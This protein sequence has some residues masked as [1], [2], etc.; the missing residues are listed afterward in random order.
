MSRNLRKCE[1]CKE[2]YDT[3]LQLLERNAQHHLPVSC[4]AC[5][6]TICHFCFVDWLT[7]NQHG[8]VKCPDCDT[9]DGFNADEPNHVNHFACLLLAST[10][11][12]DTMQPAATKARPVVTATSVKVARAPTTPSKPQQKPATV[13]PDTVKTKKRKQDETIEYDHLL[14]SDDDDDDE[15]DV[16]DDE[17]DDDDE[18]EPEPVPEKPRPTKK[19][20]RSSKLNISVEEMEA[21][22]QHIILGDD[23]HSGMERYLREEERMAN[24]EPLSEQNVRNVMRQVKKFCSGEGV[25]YKHWPKG[26]K[27][28]EGEELHLGMD[29]ELMLKAAKDFEDEYGR[30]KGNGWLLRHPITKLGNY[31][32]WVLENE[33]REAHLDDSD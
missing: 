4:K 16:D 18:L 20:K 12:D 17:D 27:F 28:L 30:D 25:E 1:R 8:F 21:L 15:D 2:V 19:K 10:A 6:Y 32:R 26:T 31:Q 24:G 13:T 7:K 11:D 22:E 9:V 29:F 14:S 3:D 5:S 33:I 23:R